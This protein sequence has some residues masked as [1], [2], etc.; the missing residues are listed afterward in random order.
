[1]QKCS[2]RVALWGPLLRSK[3]DPSCLSIDTWSDSK[4]LIVPTHLSTC[5]L[6]KNVTNTSRKVGWDHEEIPLLDD[7]DHP[8]ILQ[9]LSKKMMLFTLI[10]REF[11]FRRLWEW[12]M[13]TE[14]LY[15]CHRITFYAS[16]WEL[17]VVEEP[18]KFCLPFDE[19]NIQ[20]WGD[21]TYE[22]IQFKINESLFFE[23]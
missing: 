12:E 18:R 11:L 7:R 13:E 1:M 23:I 15:D 22:T 4:A 2:R 5:Q 10:F 19:S 16:D 9:L 3:M 14:R 20:F 17:A 8:M 21:N 6:L